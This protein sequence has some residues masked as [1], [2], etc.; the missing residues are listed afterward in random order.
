MIIQGLRDSGVFSSVI[1]AA[2]Q[3]SISKEKFLSSVE[4]SNFSRT[5]TSDRAF[6]SRRVG[7]IDFKA[8]T[9]RRVLEF[10]DDSIHPSAIPPRSPPELEDSYIAI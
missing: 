4:S 8:T 6:S 7:K 5:T 10:T 9:A 3:A 2:E 1:T